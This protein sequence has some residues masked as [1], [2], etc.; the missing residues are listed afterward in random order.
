MHAIWCA[1]HM[2][3]KGFFPFCTK[4]ACSSVSLKG[5]YFFKNEEFA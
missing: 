5:D 2:N 4:N 1:R 3:I